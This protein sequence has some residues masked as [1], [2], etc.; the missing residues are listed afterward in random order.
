M[1]ALIFVVRR[2]SGSRQDARG[3]TLEASASDAKCGTAQDE[4]AKEDLSVNDAP[5]G[6]LGDTGW[7]EAGGSPARISFAQVLASYDAIAVYRVVGR[8][9]PVLAARP[10]TSPAYEGEV[11]PAP[12]DTPTGAEGGD[13]VQASAGSQVVR[14]VRLTLQRALKGDPSQCL[15]MNVPGGRVGKRYDTFR[16]FPDRIQVGDRLLLVLRNDGASGEAVVAPQ[17][18]EVS[19]SGSAS[20][21]GGFTIDDVDTFDPKTASTAVMMDGSTG[22]SPVSTSEEP[23]P[24]TRT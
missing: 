8:D 9:L 24:P 6:E 10:Q 3:R 5:L 18:V 20:L 13:A 22:G 4:M 17:I 23:V 7:S 12:A 14:P 2:A 1:A 11:V 19:S 21:G 15:S 16:R